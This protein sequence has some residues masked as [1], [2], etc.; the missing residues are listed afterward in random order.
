MNNRTRKRKDAGPVAL[1]LLAW[2]FLLALAPLGASPGKPGQSGERGLKGSRDAGPRVR[3]A[4]ESVG[5]IYVSARASRDDDAPR[6]KGCAVIV[7]GDGVVATAYSAIRQGG[8]NDLYDEIYFARASGDGSNEKGRARRVRLR[9]A[10]I[11]R[12]ADLALLRAT[13]DSGDD[14]SREQP[15][16]P[17]IELADT[18]GIELL[19]EL[20]LIGQEEKGATALAI[21]KGVVEGVDR[22]EGWIKTDARLLRGGSGIAVDRDGRLLG[23]PVKVIAD[24]QAIDSDGDGRPDAVRQ[25]GGVAFLRPA[26]LVAAML[27]ELDGRQP[28]SKAAAAPPDEP[29]APARAQSER[30]AP[31]AIRGV[32]RAS[33]G[34]RPI[35]GARVGL[36]AAGSK[37]VTES[38]LIAWGGTNADGRFELN[39]RVP[40]GRYTVKAV[41]LGYRSY[42][43]DVEIDESTGMLVIELE[44]AR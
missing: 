40:A 43:R 44:A 31:V 25:F 13:P 16:F 39:R 9:P 21:R 27:K 28:R 37:D 4:A 42:S 3:R 10:V 12:N 20:A 29:A 8:S 15:A 17:A 38:S 22:A 1:A 5:F 30:P 23:I 14:S 18:L 26:H 19:D 7:R 32:V 35:A 6:P 33:A 2:V 41:A 24:S 34:G 36:I 11:D